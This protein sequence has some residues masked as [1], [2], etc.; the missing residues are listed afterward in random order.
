M[1]VKV[2][3]VAAVCVRGLTDDG[4]LNIEVEVRVG[5]GSFIVVVCGLE[6]FTV[7]GV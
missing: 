4:V 7:A 5:A 2:V 1:D 6:V 3:N